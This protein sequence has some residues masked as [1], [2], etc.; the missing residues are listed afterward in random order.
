MTMTAIVGKVLIEATY[1]LYQ[2]SFGM[3]SSTQTE[4]DGNEAIG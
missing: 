1:N 3:I 2:Y 4:I